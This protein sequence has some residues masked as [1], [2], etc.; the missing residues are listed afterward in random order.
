MRDVDLNIRDFDERLLR[1]VKA[2][3][4]KGGVTL[5]E[6]VSGILREAC[7]DPKRAGDRVSGV[8]GSEAH[9]GDIV[10]RSGN[11]GMQAHGGSSAGDDKSSKA[12]APKGRRMTAEEF[13]KLSNS[14]KLKAVREEKYS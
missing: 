11:R 2:V 7:G 12:G 4:A 6:Y 9:S 14:D 10:P 8:G 13:Q 5:K 3:A 1:D